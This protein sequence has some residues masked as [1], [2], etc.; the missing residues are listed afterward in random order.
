MAGRD[1][2]EPPQ[3]LMVELFAGIGTAT[4]AAKSL[5]VPVTTIAIESDRDLRNVLSEKHDIENRDL[6]NDVRTAKG[7]GIYARAQEISSHLKAIIIVAGPLCVDVAKVNKQRVGFA[8]KRTNL[9]TE[10]VRIADEVGSLAEDD[11]WPV[12]LIME[13]VMQ[14]D[15][16]DRK[17]FEELM[18]TP[19]IG[20][21]GG[22]WGWIHR[23]RLFW[24]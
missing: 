9:A 20:I 11:A 18:Q 5:D 8:G 3:I 15:A 4:F 21:H 23:S 6:S 12:I 10:A 2:P 17:H 24:V 13:N 1:L 14:Q 22:D 16:K 7:K 19:T